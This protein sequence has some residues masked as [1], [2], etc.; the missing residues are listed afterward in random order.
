MIALTGLVTSI[1][2]LREMNND[3]P[4]LL[5]AEGTVEVERERA[6]ILLAGSKT[7]VAGV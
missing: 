7:C 6:S 4:L 3:G 1:G 5:E 2:A